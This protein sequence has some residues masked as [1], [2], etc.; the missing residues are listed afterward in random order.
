MTSKVTI[1]LNMGG[2]EVVVIESE[3]NSVHTAALEATKARDAICPKVVVK[4]TGTST[5]EV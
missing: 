4:K 2:G 1:S 3:N 5:G